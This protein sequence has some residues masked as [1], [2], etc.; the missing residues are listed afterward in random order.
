MSPDKRVQVII[1][2]FLEGAAGFG[3]LVAIIAVILVD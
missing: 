3:A 2:A 1:V